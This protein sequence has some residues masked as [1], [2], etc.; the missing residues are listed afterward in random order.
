MGQ[1]NRLK[2]DDPFRIRP[3][4][5]AQLRPQTQQQRLHGEQGSQLFNG[6]DE[7]SKKVRD[8]ADIVNKQTVDARHLEQ[9]DELKLREI[10]AA[11]ESS[12][13]DE[14]PVERC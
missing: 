6:N 13:Q 3:S 14:R 12:V 8:V 10:F 2:H 11:T 7:K 1:D 4:G 5:L 9:R